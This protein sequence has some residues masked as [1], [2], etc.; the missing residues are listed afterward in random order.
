MSAIPILVNALFASTAWGL[1]LSGES[2]EPESAFTLHA[3]VMATLLVLLFPTLGVSL[4]A[5]TAQGLAWWAGFVLR[6]DQIG[7]RM[8]SSLEVRF[9]LA[10]VC[11]VQVLA[12]L[13]A[14]F[15]ATML[16]RAGWTR[17]RAAALCA[18]LSLG[19]FFAVGGWRLE[20]PLIAAASTGLAAAAFLS[21]FLVSGKRATPGPQRPTIP[22]EPFTRLADGTEVFAPLGILGERFMLPSER[23]DELKARLKAIHR[24]SWVYML[25]AH[26]PWL[27]CLLSSRTAPLAFVLLPLAFIVGILMTRSIFSRIGLLTAGLTPLPWPTAIVRD[28][29]VWCTL[30]TGMPLTFIVFCYA[31]SGLLA[32]TR[33][34]LKQEGRSL[35]DLVREV[36]ALRGTVGNARRLA[37]G[38]LWLWPMFW[39]VLMIWAFGIAGTL[40]CLVGAPV[41]L[42]LPIGL[43]LESAI[44]LLKPANIGV[45]PPVVA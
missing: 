33:E 25:V 8:L 2:P 23:A 26:A 12:A 32:P 16:L 11:A 29:L 4:L 10:K 22:T 15:I 28:F 17:A 40:V 38:V 21:A 37:I 42:V 20:G 14:P 5:L 44:P 36:G 39:G 43:I 6:P 41:A 31:C 7:F 45:R 1:S 30:S 18:A 24:R 27:L 34:R 3:A 13:L 9:I 35:V 19:A